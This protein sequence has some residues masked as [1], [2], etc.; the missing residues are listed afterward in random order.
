MPMRE[1][2]TVD[3][4]KDPRD[5]VRRRNC[6]QIADRGREQSDEVCRIPHRN[7][8]LGR[9]GSPVTSVSVTGQVESATCHCIPLSVT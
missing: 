1:C 5:I 9:P 6:A 8:S 4:Q 7:G 3:S 2:Q